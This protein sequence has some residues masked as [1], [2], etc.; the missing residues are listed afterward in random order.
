MQTAIMPWAKKNYSENNV[1]AV[2]QQILQDWW[3]LYRESREYKN[4]PQDSKGKNILISLPAK[5]MTILRKWMAFNLTSE[6]ET[7]C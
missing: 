7:N 1:E 5:E 6:D 2:L 4:V 3:T